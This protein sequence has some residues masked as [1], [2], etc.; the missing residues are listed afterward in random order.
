MDIPQKLRQARL[1]NNLTLE[2]LGSMVGQSKQYMHLLEKGDFRLSYEMAVK[3]ALAM[4][5]TPD[6]IFLDGND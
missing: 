3:I 4:G 6:E 5:T 2:K 1:S